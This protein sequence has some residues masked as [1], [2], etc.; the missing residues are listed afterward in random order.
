[1]KNR[2]LSITVLLIVVLFISACSQSSET[3]SSQ[4][5]SIGYFPNV[6]HAPAMVGI[7]AG[8]FA[9]H[10]PE[11]DLSY[12]TFAVGNLLMDAL[13]TGKI[14]IGYVGPGPVINRYLQGAKVQILA[15]ASN[16]GML[17]VANP[18]TD[19]NTTADLAGNIVATQAIG[20]SRDIMLRHLLSENNLAL[21]Q[22]GG[23]V[24]HRIQGAATIQSAFSQQQLDA[25]MAPEPWGSL[26]EQNGARVMLDWNEFPYAGQVPATIIVTSESYA[27]NNPDIIEKFLQAHKETI[28]YIE[29]NK[30]ESL[31]IMQQ[32]IRNITQQ[33]ISTEV[34]AK[35]LIRSPISLEIDQAAFTMVFENAKKMNNITNVQSEGLFYKQGGNENE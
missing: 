20:D 27:R 8:I 25:A 12:Q 18:A 34:L 21:E 26:L 17:L 1:M 2:Y 5:L 19:I 7:E 6:T 9:D 4:Q 28:I 32:Q 29:Q 24:R 31:M 15:G 3:D 35:S 14:D 23:T 13:A 33:E 16:G 10:F 11:L 22:Q 30:E